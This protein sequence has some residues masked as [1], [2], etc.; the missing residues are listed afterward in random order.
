MERKKPIIIKNIINRKE[1]INVPDIKIPKIRIPKIRLEPRIKNYYSPPEP[2]VKIVYPGHLL[3]Q[4]APSKK[5]YVEKETVP[6]Q[7]F[8]EKVK[9]VTKI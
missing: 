1:Y 5:K 9:P 7:K 3:P 2:K 8:I 6:K 4:K